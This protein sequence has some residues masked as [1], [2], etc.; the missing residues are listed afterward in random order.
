MPT[1]QPDPH[2]RFLPQERSDVGGVVAEGDGGGSPLPG[3]AG[4]PPAGGRNRAN[5]PASS[6]P[7]RETQQQYAASIDVVRSHAERLI[8][9][10][11]EAGEFDDLPG[12]G[13][14]IPGAGTVGD[15]LW[16]VRSWLRRNQDQG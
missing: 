2:F 9:E 13:R 4:T 12:T 11:M 1:G 6:L 10:A 16:W 14:P 3:S 5:Q 15:E 7:G 8:Q